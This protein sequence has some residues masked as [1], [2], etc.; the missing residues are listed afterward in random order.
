MRHYY[1]IVRKW[2]Q[3]EEGLAVLAIL[4]AAGFAGYFG[5]KLLALN[6]DA[7]ISSYLFKGAPVPSGLLMADWHANILKWP[8]AFLQGL[9]PFNI[10]T[11][12]LANCTLLAVMLLG[13]AYAAAL[14]LGRR[15]FYPVALV[16]A[17]LMASS[18]DLVNET[19]F[20]F[21]RNVEY[22]L[23]F[24]G[25][26]MF[27]RIIDSKVIRTHRWWQLVTLY[28]VLMTA[29]MASDPYFIY[30]SAPALL[31]VLGYNI[32]RKR[33]SRSTAIGGTFLAIFPVL[34]AKVLL[35]V[36]MLTK[37]FQYYGET[38]NPP[39]HQFSDLPLWFWSTIGDIGSVFN[40]DALFGQTVH[41]G[42]LNNYIMLVFMI[43][44]FAALF[45][46]TKKLR[47][48]AESNPIYATLLVTTFVLFAL[49]ILTSGF[50]HQTRFL[51]L[52]VFVM[53]TS[54]VVWIQ[55]T[56]S[57]LR[58]QHVQW[59]S[60]GT[61]LAIL[62]MMV[63]TYHQQH[64][65]APTGLITTAQYRKRLGHI[66][67]DIHAHGA[68]TLISGYTYTSTLAFAADGNLH[69]V[70][71]LYCNQNLPFLTHL[72]WYRVQP[73]TS[74]VVALLVDKNGRDGGSW[75][76]SLASVLRYYGHPL[77]ESTEPG[78]SGV[79][80]HIYYYPRSVINKVKVIKKNG[81]PVPLLAQ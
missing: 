24:L 31:I 5:T 46:S 23:F 9:I 73:A 33:Y 51:I 34:I 2:V 65:T 29:L 28:L 17:F 80:V 55:P 72:S 1:E 7:L 4:L 27:W 12:T 35:R 64:T 74:K 62:C 36:L 67:A 79:S 43:L 56:L 25:I 66:V 13:W 61:M 32:F 8:V 70:P 68:T 71:L 37:V 16:L 45:V 18:V 10:V 57:K 59:V 38:L 69:I 54:L 14:S 19:A 20:T 21:T 50:E 11:F 41:L 58:R 40:A 78:L 63:F 22:P 81:T 77:S 26:I 75:Q 48:S 6:P 15:Y 39:L 49:Y 3:P 42:L 44:A 53:C 30:A 76:C 60:G 52:P 47:Q